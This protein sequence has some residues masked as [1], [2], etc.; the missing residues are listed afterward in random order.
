MRP[1]E[2]MLVFGGLVLAIVLSL[3]AGPG[4]NTAVAGDAGTETLK[5][6]TVDVY[7]AIE[8]MMAK[9]DMKKAREDTT[10]V[11]QKKAEAIEKEMRQLEDAFKVLP[12]NDPQIADLNRQA[13]A[14]QAEYQKI[15]QD[16]Q[17]DLEKI[18][19]AQLIESYKKVREATNAVGERLGYTHVFCN[20]SF[21]RPMET[22][23]LATTLQE[24]LARPLV[25]GIAADDITKPVMAELKLE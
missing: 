9:D 18:N 13:Q 10:A 15:A 24:L 16:R 11:W 1:S 22:V 19:S 8:K 14:K 12:P 3:T 17:Q 2:R 20:R 6:G 5:V 23:T 4:R 25:R 7:V 21:D